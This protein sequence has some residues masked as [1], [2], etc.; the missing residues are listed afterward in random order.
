MARYKRGEDHPH[1]T[2][3]EN[4]VR[5]I[6]LLY[7]KHELTQREIA[8][9]FGISRESVGLIVQRRRWAHVE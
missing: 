8:Q 1:T 3:T 6:R 4:D 2:L 7:A 5:V 9:L